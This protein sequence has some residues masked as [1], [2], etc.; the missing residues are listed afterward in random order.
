MGL[1]RLVKPI[2]PDSTGVSAPVAA[3]SRA[4]AS[5]KKLPA[6]DPIPRE[7]VNALSRVTAFV[8]KNGVLSAFDQILLYFFSIHDTIN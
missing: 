3:W 7:L 4:K 6:A 5:R 1:S 2:P 8:S